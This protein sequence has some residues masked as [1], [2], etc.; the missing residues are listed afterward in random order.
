[1]D[2]LGILLYRL[3]SVS[4]VKIYKSRKWPGSLS[5]FRVDWQVLFQQNDKPAHSIFCADGDTLFV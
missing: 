2:R 3:V 1:M 4:L 5:V